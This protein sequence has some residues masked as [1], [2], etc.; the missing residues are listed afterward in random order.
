VALVFTPEM[1]GPGYLPAIE[2]AAPLLGVQTIRT[3]FRDPLEVVRVLDAFAREPNGGLMTR[4][5]SPLWA[6]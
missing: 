5:M 3:P 1:V 6:P 2:A 4:C